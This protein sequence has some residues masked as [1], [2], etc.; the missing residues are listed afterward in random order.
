MKYPKVFINEIAT[1]APETQVNQLF[2][3]EAPK[4]LDNDKKRKLFQ[5][6]AQKGQIEKRY[7]VLPLESGDHG[8]G[9]LEFYKKS[10]FPSTDQRM[11]RYKQH[12]LP[13][14]KKTIE[15][16][17]SRTSELQDITH[18]IVTSCTGFYAPGLDIEIVEH[19]GL[20]KNVERSIIGFMGCYAAFNAMK[21]AYHVVRSQPEAKVLMVNIE[22]CTL[23][24]QE[25]SEI[26][27][28]L[29]FLIFADGCAASI[30][31]AESE[32]LE[33]QG[34]KN[35]LC[36][37]EVDKITWDVGDQ[38]F[39]MYLST[40]VPKAIAKEIP[41]KIDHVLEG[42]KPEDIELWALHPG[43]RAILDALATQIQITD[44]KM[45]PSRKVL[46]NFG[47]MS[48]P[49]VVFVL[50]EHLYNVQSHGNGC[51][52]AFGPGLTIESMRFH[53]KML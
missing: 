8:K 10:Q 38:G 49:S 31:S 18:V 24:F 30:I 47:N 6:M 11:R 9:L 2:L 12:A 21:Q 14:V 7:S 26:E 5:R 23:H 43:G 42:V 19:L 44:V 40:E 37:D 39:D 53:K 27:P 32:G 41:S 15:N 3:E 4:Y 45:E 29:G 50:K 16:L 46:R 34:F 51:A 48:S 36:S 33:I 35:Y 1:A 13:L 22:L 17:K 28:M 25:S 52:M 20:S